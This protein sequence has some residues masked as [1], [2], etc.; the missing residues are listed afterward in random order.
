[1]SDFFFFFCFVLLD[2]DNLMRCHRFS[3]D[4]FSF[5]FH[6]FHGNFLSVHILDLRFS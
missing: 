4:M 2:A 1:M 3:E 5:N 6:L